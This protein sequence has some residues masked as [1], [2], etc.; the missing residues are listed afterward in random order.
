MAET[1][2]FTKEPEERWESWIG[3]GRNG[4]FSYSGGSF[5]VY[6]ISYSYSWNLETKGSSQ[7]RQRQTVYPFRASKSDLNVVLQFSSM[8]ELRNFGS[9]ARGYHESVTSH[10]GLVGTNGV[11][12]M[13]FTLNIPSRKYLS[14]DKNEKNKSWVVTYGGRSFTYGVALPSINVVQSNDSIAP[15]MRLTLKILSGADFDSS[16]ET[17]WSSGS[18]TDTIKESNVTYESVA[19]GGD[20][21][22]SSATVNG[23][24]LSKGGH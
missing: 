19:S 4:V 23:I 20:S 11:P 14:Y 5:A 3:V 1:E 13:K 22:Y 18:L 12:N 7:A 2:Y 15:T 24:G 21:A 9:F 16:T 8:E 17:S 10:S 6:V